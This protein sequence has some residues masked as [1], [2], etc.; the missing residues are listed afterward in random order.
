[1]N[2]GIFNNEILDPGTLE[3]TGLQDP[4][5][6]GFVTINAG[7]PATVDITSVIGVFTNAQTGITKEVLFPGVTAHTPA[8]FGT[9]SPTFYYFDDTGTLVER[10]VIEVSPFINDHCML[11]IST[12]DSGAISGATSYS[13]ITRQAGSVAFHNFMNSV[14]HIRRSGLNAQA[15]GANLKLDLTSGVSIVPSINNRTDL[16]NP[17]IGTF[18]GTIGQIFF[19]TWRSDGTNGETLQLINSDV[20]T[21]V[22]DDGTAIASDSSPQGLVQSNKWVAHHVLFIADFNTLAIQYGQD[23]FQ[24]QEDAIDGI[25][26]EFYETLPGLSSTLPI[27]S[28]VMRGAASDLSSSSDAVFRPSDRVGNFR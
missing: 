20:Q 16:K 9:G 21:G 15:N 24:S 19:E 14:Q 27:A 11:G 26:S 8:N 3:P 2:Q 13:F 10:S 12:D 28:L 1:M 6:G 7:D 17:H 25:I 4:T 22:Y 23:I 18:T 5:V